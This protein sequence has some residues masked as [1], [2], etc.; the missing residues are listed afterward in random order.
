MSY[1]KNADLLHFIA[2]HWTGSHVTAL[3]YS[4]MNEVPLFC[5]NKVPTKKNNQQKREP[6]DALKH[7]LHRPVPLAYCS[8]NGQVGDTKP[9]RFNVQQISVAA[10]TGPHMLFSLYLLLT[11]PLN[12][13][14]QPTYKW[15]KKKTDTFLPP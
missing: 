2:V 4:E 14:F 1:D 6:C 10:R 12:V 8:R 7:T 9:L 13:S 5:T 3:P 15:K 11:G